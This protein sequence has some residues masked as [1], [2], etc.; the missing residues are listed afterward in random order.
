MLKFMRDNQIRIPKPIKAMPLETI[1]MV[2]IKKRYVIDEMAFK[3]APSSTSTALSLLLESYWDGLA[4][5][6]DKCQTS[7]RLF[8]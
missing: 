4:S 5:G 7:E 8:R 1:K 3:R 2:N 6:K